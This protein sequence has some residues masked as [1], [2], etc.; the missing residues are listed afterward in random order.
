MTSRAI[1]AASRPA[2][3]ADAS[4]TMRASR[5]GSGRPPQLLSFRR[6]ASLG[7]D[8]AERAQQR[9]CL[10]ERGP[11][12][13]IEKRQLVGIGD[14]PLGEVEHQRGEI[15]REDLGTPERLERGG[16]A[17]VPQPIA[18][19]RLGAARAAA[20]LI[21]GGTR[22]AH[23]LEPG[24][25]D[26]RLVARHARESGIDDD[27]DA[28]DRQRG[29]GDRGR[30]HDLASPGRRGGDR[31]ILGRGVERPIKRDDVGRGVVEALL[32]PRLGPAD[33][34]G[35]GQEHQDGAPLRPQCPQR[36]VGDLRL[37]RSFRIAADVMRRDRKRAA[38][39]CDHRRVAEMARDARAVDR[40][41]HDQQLEVLAQPALG[42]AREREAEIGVERALVEFVEQHGRDAIER[43]IIEHEPREHAL[44]HHLDAGAA[45]DFRAEPHPIADR[46]SHLLAERR[47]HALGRGARRDPARLQHEDLAPFRPGLVDEH[48]RHPRGL[49]GAGRRDQDRGVARPQCGRERWQRIVDRQREFE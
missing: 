20:T 38:F 45:R 6:D 47:R 39:A 13:R 49:A 28:V 11:G 40:R 14:A 30:Q 46:F 2:P 12:W 8:R 31:A 29:L 48:Q 26:V 25:S 24:Q 3:S 19:A 44:G 27:A 4:T 21:G 10:G 5:G 33:L 23:R 7:V 22:H 36:R 34:G 18:D 35:A 43:G 9:L 37:D 17:L 16:L 42:V 1:S 32:E 15:G 41:R